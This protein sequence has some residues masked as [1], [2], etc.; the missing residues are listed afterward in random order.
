[1]TDEKRRWTMDDR[2]WPSRFYRP[3]SVVHRLPS[4]ARAVVSVALL[5]AMGTFCAADEYAPLPNMAPKPV[6]SSPGKPVFT[7]AKLLNGAGQAVNGLQLTVTADHLILPEA[8]G[9]IGQPLIITPTT[10]HLL[11]K[12]VSGQPIVLDAYNLSLTR[13]DMIVVGPEKQTVAF[14]RKAAGFRSRKA[15][16]IDYPQIEPGN[17]FVPMTAVNPIHF[18]GDF[19]LLFS[20]GLYQPGEYKVQVV[21]TRAAAGESEIAA[22]QGRV[23]SNT[24]TFRIQ[25]PKPPPPPEQATPA[26]TPEPP[27]QPEPKPTPPPADAPQ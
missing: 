22:W 1:M 13:L 17:V 6:P 14:T 10:L 9:P 21:Y 15:L 24:L 23:V 12:N 25:G 4:I 16:P 8:L 20:Y 27:P 2:R 3:S 7:E 11:F 26:T 19:N 5:A 18:P